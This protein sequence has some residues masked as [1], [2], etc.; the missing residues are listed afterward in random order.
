[1]ANDMI[2]AVPGSG[3]TSYIANAI[4]KSIVEGTDPDSIFAITFTRKAAEELKKRCHKDIHA[5]TIHSLAYYIING[6][7]DYENSNNLFYYDNILKE[8]LAKKDMFRA[9]LLAIDEAQDLSLHQYN[10]VKELCGLARDVVIV[11][12]YKQSIYSFNGGDPKFMDRLKS[13]IESINISSLNITYRIPEEIASYVNRVFKP[14]VKLKA[15]TPG[16]EVNIHST[17]I[18]NM[19]STALSESKDNTAILVRTNYEVMKLVRLAKSNEYDVN[20]TIPVKE[21]PFIMF[22]SAIVN[23]KKGV[24]LHDFVKASAIVGGFSYSTGRMLKGLPNL[25]ITTATLDDITNNTGDV[26]FT[27]TGRK[28]ISNFISTINMYSKFY[29]MS[30]RDEIYSLLHKLLHDGYVIDSIWGE[31]SKELDI[32]VDYIIDI[33]NNNID[34]HYIVDNKASRSIMTTHSSKGKEFDNVSLLINTKNINIFDEEEMRVA[35]VGCTRSKKTLDI[36]INETYN[37]DRSRVSL[38]N[39]INEAME[40]L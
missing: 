1:M 38:V 29:G 13:D 39:M 22:T 28:E 36:F 30:T 23:L 25:Y 40:I 5:S 35:Y 2:I 18:S 19:Y 16:G 20:Y 4:N 9:N 15:I 12:D 32:M 14:N 21:H 17:P 31:L 8:A 24:R 10:L 26:V 33:T 6:K 37:V 27:T 3:K 34:P 7:L 11:G